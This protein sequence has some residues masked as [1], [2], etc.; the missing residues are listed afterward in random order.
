MT[1]SDCFFILGFCI[2]ALSPLILLLRSP[3]PF[4]GPPAPAD[5]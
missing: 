3:P 2:L 4:G 5:H 1:Y